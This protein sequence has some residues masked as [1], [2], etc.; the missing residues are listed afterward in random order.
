VK[1]SVIIPVFNEVL[2][3]AAV[4]SRV[5]AVEVGMEREVIVVDDGST[6]GTSEALRH[7]GSTL[8]P[9]ERGNFRCEH[10]GR[11]RGKGS[12]LRRG[13]AMAEGDLVLFQDADLEL[14]PEDYPLL[15]APILLGRTSVVFGR[16]SYWSVPDTHLSSRLAN[17]AL[18]LLTTLLYGQLIVDMETAYK[19]MRRDAVRSLKLVSDGFEIEPEL[20]AK[21]RRTG[22]RILEVPIRYSPRSAAQGKKM[23]WRDGFLAIWTLLRWRFAPAA[24]LLLSEEDPR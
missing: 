19:V 3:V 9:E 17:G 16:R 7:L 21:L 18:A 23:K 10:V 1:L 12:A 20:T 5:M 4:V 2:T 22:H 11:N 15:L 8:S 14:A 6:D 13:L 24:A